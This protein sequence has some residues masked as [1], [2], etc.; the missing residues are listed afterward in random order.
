VPCTRH[1]ATKKE[2]K[3]K[4][5]FQVFYLFPAAYVFRLVLLDT[6]VGA[7]ALKLVLA[8]GQELGVLDAE[9]VVDDL[10]VTNGVDIALDVCNLLR[11]EA[12]DDM[13]DAIDC[14]G[15]RV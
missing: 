3:K 15:N 4:G 6:P 7:L 13:E 2:K 5:Y 14:D 8:L 10:E 1:P 12:T 11:I 9:L